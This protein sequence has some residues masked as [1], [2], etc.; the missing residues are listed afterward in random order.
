MTSPKLVELWCW[1]FF[2]RNEVKD[3]LW[4]WIWNG[5]IHGICSLFSN[6]PPTN[7]ISIWQLHQLHATSSGPILAVYCVQWSHSITCFFSKCFKI[8]HIFAQIFNCV[9]LFNIFFALFMP[10]FWKIACMP[11]RSRIGPALVETLPL[12][13]C[14]SNYFIQLLE[15]LQTLLDNTYPQHLQ[16]A[17]SWPLLTI[18]CKCIIY[19][20]LLP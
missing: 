1:R 16:F 7:I 2:A 17:L 5:G 4:G 8:V 14:Y 18:S 19:S 10:F 12:Y 9:A 6:P 11:S 3:S 15:F 13:I 20:T